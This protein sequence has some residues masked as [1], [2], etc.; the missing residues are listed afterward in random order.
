MAE[1]KQIIPFIYTCN[2]YV[3]CGSI[4]DA[5]EDACKSYRLNEWGFIGLADTWNNEIEHGLIMPSLLHVLWV[6]TQQSYLMDLV[7]REIL[8]VGNGG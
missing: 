8:E 4:R 2:E 5:V 6:E 7:D 1:F 3:N